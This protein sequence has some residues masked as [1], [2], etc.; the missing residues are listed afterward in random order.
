MREAEFKFSDI[1]KVIRA[2]VSLSEKL[3]Y[4]K[5][6][7]RM[8][9]Y[10]G[11]NIILVITNV[12]AYLSQVSSILH[13]IGGDIVLVYTDKKKQCKVNIRIKEELLREYNIDVSRDLLKNMQEISYGGHKTLLN[14]EYKGKT[15]CKKFIERFISSFTNYLED[16]LSTKFN[17]ISI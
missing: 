2:E 5:A 14:I 1:Y 17:E 10:R 12:S 6:L 13:R 3:A 7:K 8:K 9:V 4:L 11:N 16:T 15:S